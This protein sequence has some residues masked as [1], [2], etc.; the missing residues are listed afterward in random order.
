[1]DKFTKDGYVGVVATSD[2]INF[3]VPNSSSDYDKKHKVYNTYLKKWEDKW[4]YNSSGIIIHKLGKQWDESF[5]LIFPLKNIPQG[6]GRGD[7]ERAVGN[8][9]IEKGVPIL[10]FYSHIY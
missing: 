2:D 5:V 8:L 1:M 4:V 9:L 10:D 6:Y 7:V 3:D